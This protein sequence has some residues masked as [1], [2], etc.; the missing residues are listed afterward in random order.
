MKRIDR[1]SKNGI[2][3]HSQHLWSDAERLFVELWPQIEGGQSSYTKA[4]VCRLAGVSLR[5]VEAIVAAARRST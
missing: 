2:R 1:K 4:E 3:P 5:W